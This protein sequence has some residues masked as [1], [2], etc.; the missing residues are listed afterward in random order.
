[1]EDSHGP[2]VAFDKDICKAVAVAVLGKNAKVVVKGYPDDQTSM[3]ALRAGEID[4]IASLS[5]DFA[6]TTDADIAL[7][8]P[9]LYDAVG[10]MVPIAS[11]VTKVRELIGKKICFL[12]GTETEVTLRAWFESR[13]L[14]FV[15][16]PFSGA[17]GDGGG[18]HY[19]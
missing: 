13:H 15:P 19:E 17:G 16:F 7:T 3:A 10:V 9:V 4:V 1:M 5:A 12:T 18:L 14:E 8:R 11:G 6:H 2:R